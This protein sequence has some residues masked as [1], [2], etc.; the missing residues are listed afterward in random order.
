MANTKDYQNGKIY[1]IRN[2]IDDEVYVGSTCQPLSKRMAVH[3]DDMKR[4]TK[5]DRKVYKHMNELGINNFYIELY[6]KY[7]CNNCEELTKREGQIIREIGTLNIKI[8]GRTIQEYREDNKDKNKAYREANKETI[9]E[10]KKQWREANKETLSE[11]RKE[12]YEANKNKIIEQVRGYRFNNKEKVKETRKAYYEKNKDKISEQM[13]KPYTCECGRIMRLQG[14]SRHCK[15][16]IHQD[17]LSSQSTTDTSTDD[18]QK[19]I[20]I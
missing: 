5:C 7:P 4:E 20:L 16:K 2:H 15:S 12:H 6:E 19:F 10:Q 13:C 8:E 14:K 9:S 18:N 17:Y 1:T 11:K 3:R